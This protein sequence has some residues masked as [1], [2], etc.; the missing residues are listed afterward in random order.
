MATKIKGTGDMSWS[1]LLTVKRTN[2]HQFMTLLIGMSFLADRENKVL[3][4][5]TR[6]EKSSNCL[7]IVGEDKYLKV[8]H[9]DVGSKSSNPVRYAPILVQ[10]QQG[11]LGTGTWKAPIT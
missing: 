6:Y 8:D 2:R 4:C 11:S 3:V 5:P 7:H 10:I 9:Q 1:K